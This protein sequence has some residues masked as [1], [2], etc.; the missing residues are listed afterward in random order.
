MRRK[1]VNLLLT[2]S[3]VASTL[4]VCVAEA[5]DREI[6]ISVLDQRK[7]PVE[8][9]SP[10]DLVVREDGVA[11]E[12]LRVRKATTPLTIA[13]LL[14]DSAAASSAIA[15]LRKG[16]TEFLDM[17]DPTAEVALV[18]IGERSTLSVNYTRDRERLKKGVLRVFA[19]EG[20][21]AYLLDAL[22]DV[23]R[24]LVKRAPERPVIVTVMTEGVEF[25]TLTYQ[26]VLEDLYNSRA[27]FYALVLGVVQA[28]QHA[29]EIRNRNIVLDEGPRGTGGRRD[30]L[31]SSMAIGP[32]L[33][34]LAAE[35]QH[36]WI[37]TYS[38]PESLIQPERVQVEA[39]RSGL[40]V[41]ARTRLEPDRVAK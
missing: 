15:D 26:P 1:S 20:S 38:H 29:D 31:L 13:L 2:A 7:S 5:A 34:E 10:A 39:R 4:P 27:Q 23:S 8:S 17:L 18:T 9:L 40:T 22:K 35:L 3:F 21:G 11:R 14:D 36:Q 24:G 16:V 19:R 33:K 41:R 6:V 37:V 30:Q 28:N 12:V 32:T 25:S